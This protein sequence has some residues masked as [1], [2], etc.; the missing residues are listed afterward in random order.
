MLTQLIEEEMEEKDTEDGRPEIG[1]RLRH[2]LQDED[3]KVEL[4]YERKIVDITD[5]TL[6]DG[7]DDN[8]TWPWSDILQDLV[9]L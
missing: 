1:T 6:Y 4:W 5:T 2:K 7:Y 3:N 8:F 9:L